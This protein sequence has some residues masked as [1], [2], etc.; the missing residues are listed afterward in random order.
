VP[1]F[2]VLGLPPKN[3]QERLGHAT[4]TMTLDRYGHLFRGD[5]ADELEAAESALLA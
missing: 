1:G 5:D 4:I 2:E 3:V